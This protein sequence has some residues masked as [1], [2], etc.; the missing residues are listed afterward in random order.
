[1]N[2]KIINV[3]WLNLSAF[4]ESYQ[5]V[6]NFNVERP[7]T[8]TTFFKFPDILVFVIFMPDMNLCVT[9]IKQRHG[10]IVWKERLTKMASEVS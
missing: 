8:E 6:C 4:E 9:F 5:L 3:Y 10:I 2:M 7:N 1:M